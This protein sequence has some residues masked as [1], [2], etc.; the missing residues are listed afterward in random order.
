M[1]LIKCFLKKFK[2]IMMIFLEKCFKNIRHRKIY[3]ISGQENHEDIVKKLTILSIFLGQQ[4]LK[5]MFK[6]HELWACGL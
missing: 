3:T 5:N 1:S 2:K 4:V 6:I